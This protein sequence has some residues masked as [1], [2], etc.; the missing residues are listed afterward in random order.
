MQRPCGF[1]ALGAALASALASATCAH[2]PARFDVAARRTCLVLSAGGTRGVAE[3]GAIEAIRRAGL[4]ISCVVGTSVG[5]LVGALY[6]SAPDADT[7]ERFLGLT[8]AYVA[9][10][11]REAEGRGVRTGL[12]LAAVAAAITGGLLGPA[13]AA[14]GGYLI[15]AGTVTQ[16]DRGRLERVLR[17]EL[18]GARIEALPIAFAALHH[19]REQQG[20]RLVV[21]RAGDLAGAVGASIANPFVFDD[22]D[23][24]SA[25]ALDPGSDR[26]AATPV[27]DACRQFPDSNL[28]VVNV[29]GTPAVHTASTACPIREIMV[30]VS[31]VPP[32]SLL[33]RGATDGAFESAWRAG[34]DRTAAGL[35]TAR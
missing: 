12:A 2:H 21:S 7:T 23:V 19:E 31:A 6:A 28:L 14:V 16:A 33:A 30:E 18:R 3:L 22:I 35:A 13:T 5:A 25:P 17:V 34:Y 27:E 9:E 29:S 1:G 10:T 4:P 20:L 11:R 8:T 15:G 32:E 24:A 26:L